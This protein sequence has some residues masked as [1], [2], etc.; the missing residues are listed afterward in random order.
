MNCNQN[1]IDEQYAQ[2]LID[3]LQFDYNN[4]LNNLKNSVISEKDKAKLKLKKTDKHVKLLSNII[5]DALNL[6]VLL[7]EVK[8]VK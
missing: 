6:K 3:D 4:L 2:R 1:R 8:K 7:E 5:S